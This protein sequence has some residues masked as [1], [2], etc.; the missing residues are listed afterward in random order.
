[1]KLLQVKSNEMALVVN[2]KT[3][4]YEI[5]AEHIPIINGIKDNQY[6]WKIQITKKID[7]IQSMELDLSYRCN[8]WDAAF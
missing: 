6:L 4:A 5:A 8:Q 3:F 2:E 1:M 7:E